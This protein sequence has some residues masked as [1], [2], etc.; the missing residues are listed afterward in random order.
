MWEKERFR[1]LV[2][3][4]SLG[5]LLVAC[6]MP[7]EQVPDD[8]QPAS[9]APTEEPAQDL[10]SPDTESPIFLEVNP[11]EVVLKGPQCQ[12][13]GLEFVVVLEP[14][15]SG[16]ER[17][18]MRYRL[19]GDFPDQGSEW[20]EV[21]LADQGVVNDQAAYLGQF[22]ELG[23]QAMD[24][25]D[26][27]TGVLEYQLTAEDG[28]GNTSL[29][30]QQDPIDTLGVAPCPLGSELTI[31]DGG[32]DPQFAEYGPVQGCENNLATFA[33]TLENAEHL[34]EAWVNLRWYL[35]DFEAGDYEPA[36]QP[37]KLTM[38]PAGPSG[39]YP[40]AV[41]F[42]A[43]VEIF[44]GGM[45]YLEGQDG[46]LS[47]RMHAKDNNGTVGEWPPGDSQP[48]FVTACTG[49]VAPKPTATQGL[50]LVL[51]T[52]TPPLQLAPLPSPTPTLGLNIIPADLI[53]ASGQSI[54][55][56]HDEAFDFDGGQVVASNSPEADFVMLGGEDPY[57]DDLDPVN[58]SYLGWAGFE[59][60]TKDS[61][62]ILKS[63]SSMTIGWPDH[64]ESYYCFDTS[65]GR[66]A[67]LKLNTY[68]S[69]PLSERRLIFDFTTY[70]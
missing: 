7:G 24:L 16:I 22:P 27:G 35:G 44:E 67:W 63:V 26:D 20:V 60:G 18:S 45:Q 57:L 36:S 14:D 40:G 30:P 46:F 42:A 28:A 39:E 15:P 59:G 12:P 61:C 17:V 1:F 54:T 10:A 5:L 6:N 53:H 33:L 50:I 25:F 68:V 11:S 70:Q 13:D 47:W 43:N 21:E 2:L 41:V 23:G 32:L 51:P 65:D 48:I 4:M 9:P 19:E 29:W 66:V 38:L 62:N 3:L 52:A 37:T 55:L 58:G 49:D 34:N 8:I 69:Q 64:A 56:E 31:L